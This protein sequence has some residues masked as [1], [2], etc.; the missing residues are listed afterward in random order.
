MCIAR[1]SA[2]GAARFA[3]AVARGVNVLRRQCSNPGLV[4]P[5]LRRQCSAAALARLS[6][7]RASEPS[8]R[9][10]S[11][12][13]TTRCGARTLVRA[14]QSGTQG[15][16][17]CSSPER[18][19]RRGPWSSRPPV[20]LWSL[21]RATLRRETAC[22]PTR[23]SSKFRKA[24]ASPTQFPAPSEGR[25]HSLRRRRP[26]RNGHLRSRSD[27]RFKQNRFRQQRRTPPPRRLRRPRC[28]S[29]KRF[30]QRGL[31]TS[32]ERSRKA[33]AHSLLGE[34]KGATHLHM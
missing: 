29:R 27:D 30:L 19:G 15:A 6:R 16:C 12:A 9:A 20:G 10:V 18:R 31:P 3:V 11:F 24:A 2:L 23:L 32:H 21:W 25:A 1:C 22:S 14:R 33:A 13:S 5:P 17:A 28:L 4:R 8:P 26:G 7:G 34:N